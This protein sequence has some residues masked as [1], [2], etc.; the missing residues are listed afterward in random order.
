M[1]PTETEIATTPRILE[2]QQLCREAVERYRQRIVEKPRFEHPWL[3]AGLMLL[4][5]AILAGIVEVMVR[6]L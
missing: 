2:T 3:V 6:W 5:G 4:S 1:N